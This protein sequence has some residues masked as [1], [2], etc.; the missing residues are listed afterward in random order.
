MGAAQGGM[1][2]VGPFFEGQKR[3]G[4][5]LT[6]NQYLKVKNTITGEIKIHKGKFISKFWIILSFYIF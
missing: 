2:C 4:I 6:K 1:F 5:T 3:Q